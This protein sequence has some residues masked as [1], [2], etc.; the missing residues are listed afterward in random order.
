MAL[1]IFFGHKGNFLL[2]ENLA[3]EK[4]NT[5]FELPVRSRCDSKLSL[6]GSKAASRLTSV[7]FFIEYSVKIISGG[8]YLQEHCTPVIWNPK[9]DRCLLELLA[10]MFTYLIFYSG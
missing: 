2:V 4:G 3:N 1:L 5:V 10:L 7:S 6:F 9:L 8:H